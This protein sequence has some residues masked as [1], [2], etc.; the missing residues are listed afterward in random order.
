MVTILLLLAVIGV[1]S[2]LAY[3]A[4]SLSQGE[5]RGITLQDVIN[6]KRQV[7][8][9]TL[10][11]RLLQKQAR[12]LS[13][14]HQIDSTAQKTLDAEIPALKAEN[15]SLRQ[16]LGLFEEMLKR[17]DGHGQAAVE[18]FN[19]FV[20]PDGQWH[21]HLLLNAGTDGTIFTGKYQISWPASSSV[22]AGRIPSQAGDSQFQLNFHSMTRLEGNLPGSLPSG[23]PL[24]IEILPERPGSTSIRYQYTLP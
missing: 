19:V 15:L 12:Q 16:Q 22:N 7:N 2:G 14:M 4:G 11:N 5:F 13:M 8:N 3:L 21:Y 10:D 17:P 9:L 1:C 24:L 23:T 20:Q 18:L 6:L